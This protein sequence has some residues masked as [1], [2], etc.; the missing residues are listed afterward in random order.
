MSTTY[1]RTMSISEIVCQF[2]REL[3]T[4]GRVCQ[5]DET[6]VRLLSMRLPPDVLQMSAA[7][8]DL[9]YER[10][11]DLALRFDQQRR[12]AASLAPD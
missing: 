2:K 12:L 11:L 4:C 10:L 5:T 6:R 1:D 9:T 8:P 7:I 3:V